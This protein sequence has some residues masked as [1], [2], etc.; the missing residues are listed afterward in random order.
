MGHERLSRRTFLRAGAG[1]S[2]GLPFLEAMTPGG[3]AR[4]AHAAEV[5]RLVIWLQPLSIY[6]DV[7]WPT[8]PG[9]KPYNW[10]TDPIKEVYW[11]GPGAMEND[12]YTLPDAL[13]GLAPH[14]NDLTFVEGLDNSAS[15]HDAYSTTLTGTRTLAQSP[16]DMI[17]I[18]QLIAKRLNPS[19]KFKSLQVGVRN[20]GS[21][22]KSGASW[23]SKSQAAPA[24]DNPTKLWERLFV[25]VR[26]D[27]TQAEALRKKKRSVLDAALG[28][29]TDLKGKLGP[30][31]RQKV[32]Q[33]LEAFREVEKSLD[34]GAQMGCNPPTKPSATSPS[35]NEPLFEDDDL[36]AIGDTPHVMKLQIDM[37]AMAMA[38][39]LTRIAT[40]QFGTEAN[41]GTF[42][43]LGLP[44]WRWHDASH[45]ENDA[46]SE[47]PAQLGD[48]EA[49][50]NVAQWS[51]GQF[52]YLVQ[53]MKD[54]GAFDGMVAMFV[55]SMNHGG[56]HKSRN[57][58]VLLAGSAGGALRTGRHVRLPNDNNGGGK[59]R[60]FNDLHLT[61]AHA[62]GVP[63]TQFGDPALST[64]PITQ[65][66]K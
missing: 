62:M 47:W 16:A 28:Q 10:R 1:V 37:L 32:D 39:D 21:G 40:F 27:P 56:A 54:L 49:W 42:P 15:N 14:R 46:P 51:V 44:N 30:T 22:N 12:Q 31:D 5:K 13:S 24:T 60:V 61:L 4:R 2:L 65:I 18:D 35:T 3:S 38:C 58:P 20:A 23:L 11:S 53:R 63:I 34:V 59:T 17:S 19:T 45:F 25:D 57:C 43:W 33:Y 36:R 29:A 66:L 48:A 64:G 52:G 50:R 9:A 8:A 6:S 41:N 7:F 55:T 26:A